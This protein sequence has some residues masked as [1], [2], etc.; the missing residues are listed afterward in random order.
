MC[1]FLLINIS[2]YELLSVGV[3]IFVHASERISVYIY[4]S[5][6]ECICICEFVFSLMCVYT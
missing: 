2:D 5:L 6:H 4:L 3:N 1:A